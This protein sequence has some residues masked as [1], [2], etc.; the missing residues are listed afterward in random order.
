MKKYWVWLSRLYQIG[1]KK[2]NELIKKYKTPK[3]IWNLSEEE[4]NQVDFLAKQERKM[5]LNKNYRMNIDKYIEYMDKN[6]I[7][8]I[9]I[10]DKNY[11]QKLKQIYDPPI[12]IYIKGNKKILNH[13]SIAVIGSRS[14]SNYGKVIAKEVGDKLARNNII[15]VSG[16]ARGIDAYAH[17]GAL[18]RTA[19]SIAVVGCGLDRVYPEEN[20]ELFNKIIENDGAIIS[21]YIIGTEPKKENF[22]SRNRVISGIS[23]GVLVVEAST[24]SGTFITVDFALEQGKEVY[25]VPRRYF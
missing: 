2:Q 7:S 25:S 24:Q 17:I 20:R 19:S 11:P 14:C 9:T 15:V 23:D 12:V 6:G 16:L 3:R 22:P 18:R 5:I 8:I 10:K 21:E 13:K 1:A 4:L